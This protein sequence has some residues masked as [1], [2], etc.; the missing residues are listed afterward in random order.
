MG[1]PS[2]VI[3]L[4]FAKNDR[5]AFVPLTCHFGS[6]VLDKHSVTIGNY[7]DYSENVRIFLLA[8][9]LPYVP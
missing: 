5:A 8:Q 7:K 2:S 3:V 6:C 9:N 1:R 4:R